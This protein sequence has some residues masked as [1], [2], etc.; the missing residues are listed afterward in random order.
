MS[1]D[2]K[3]ESDKASLN[4]LLEDIDKEMGKI[5]SLCFLKTWKE[6]VFWECVCVC[7]CAVGIC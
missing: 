3:M 1:R 2:D 7:V 4:N 5:V 6:C